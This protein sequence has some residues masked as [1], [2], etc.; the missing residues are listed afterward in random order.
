MT[1]IKLTIA[2]TPFLFCT[3]L[4]FGSAIPLTS[5]TFHRDED[6]QWILAGLSLIRRLDCTHVTSVSRQECVKIRVAPASRFVAYMATLKHDG[7]RYLVMTHPEAAED[8]E[9]KFNL[10][11]QGGNLTGVL[12]L[13]PLADRAFGHPLFIFRIVAFDGSREE[14]LRQCSDHRG[15]IYST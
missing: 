10:R 5:T 8:E 13:D 11:T 7:M 14:Q 1:P 2:L 3:I 15:L 6:K 12:V 9:E 4:T